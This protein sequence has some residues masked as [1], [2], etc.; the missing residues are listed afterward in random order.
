MPLIKRLFQE[1][2]QSYFLFGPRGTGK[3]TLMR[4]RHKDAIWVDLL[5][6]EVFRN[7]LARPER[8]NELIKGNPHQNTVVIDEVQKAPDLLS[9]VH[10]E[11]IQQK[12]VLCLPCED[13]LLHLKPDGDLWD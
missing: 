9:V 13:F 4:T 3:S 12:N 10:S 6:P 5:K 8:L 1:P 7:Y 2:T 11:R